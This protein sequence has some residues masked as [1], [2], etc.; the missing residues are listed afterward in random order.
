MVM[1][2][3]NFYVITGGPGGGKTT[4]LEA[5]ALKGYNYIPETARQIIK[6]RLSKGLTPRPDPKAFAREIFEQDWTNFISNS[7]LS[8][9]L[10]FDR[11]F[12]DSA[13]MLFDAHVKSYEQIANTYMANR[14]NNKVFVTPPWN[15]IY[16]NDTERDQSFEQSIQVYQR[17][18]TW[19]RDHGYDI[20]VLPKDTIETRV[21]FILR[22]VID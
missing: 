1:T 15:E 13:C 12:I 2:K 6:Q 14:F 17:L 16:Q 21:N 9:L 22:Q 5:L 19:Y 10:F 4:L 11:S 8:S 7:N 3:D 20:I 18:A